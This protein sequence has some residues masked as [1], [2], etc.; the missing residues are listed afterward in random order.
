M[1]EMKII[2]FLVA[3]AAVTLVGAFECSYQIYHMTRIDA[4]ARGLKHPKFWGL[5]AMNGN[6]SGGLI[7]YLIGRRKYPIINMSAEDS[8]E[9]ERRKKSA[10]AGLIFLTIGA[11]GLVICII[12]Q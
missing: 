4:E 7:M 11:M 5:F 8:K 12:F 2:I 1:M 9:I 3:F 10:G 6:N